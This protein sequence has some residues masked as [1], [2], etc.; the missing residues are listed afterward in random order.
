[1]RAAARAVIT[2]PMLLVQLRATGEA[3]AKYR[4]DRLLKPELYSPPRSLLDLHT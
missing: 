3:D 1:M 4:L 2:V